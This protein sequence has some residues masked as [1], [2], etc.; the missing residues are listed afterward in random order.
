MKRFFIFILS[1]ICGISSINA[2]K[3]KTTMKIPKSAK[4]TIPELI[5]KY[6]FN[7]AVKDL[8]SA[9]ALKTKKKQPVAEESLLLNTARKGAGMLA[10]TQN[11]CI[12]DSVVLAKDDFLKGIKLNKESG[13][14]TP[15]NEFFNTTT[16]PESYVFTNGL[17]NKC[18]YSQRDSSGHLSIYTSDKLAG[19][20]SD[21]DKVKGLEDINDDI[22]YPFMM[23]DGTTLY[24]S[25]KGPES[26][27]GYDIFVTRYDAENTKFLKPENIGMPFNSPA[28]DYMYAE[29]DIDSIGWFVSDRNQKAGNVCVYIFIPSETRKIYDSKVYSETEIKRFARIESIK[30]TWINIADRNAYLEKYNQLVAADNKRKNKSAF[31]FV[32]NDNITYHNISDFKSHTGKEL[33]ISLQ[34]MQKKYAQQEKDLDDMRDKYHSSDDAIKKNMRAKILEAENDIEKLNKNIKALEKSIRNNENTLLNK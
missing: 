30:N 28:N 11:I 24:F 13:T 8:Q 2:Q 18:Y 34:D 20:W 19:K 25:A 14:I 9:I 4:E 22:N 29:N 16:Q 23:A 3:A 15:Y 27:G 7:A 5:N 26:I 10:A 31:E 32:I 12:I 1:I 33:F 6:E 17:G 21:P